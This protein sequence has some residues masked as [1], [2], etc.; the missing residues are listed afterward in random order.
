[1]AHSGVST[2]VVPQP[3]NL[4]MNI[5]VDAEGDLTWLAA[6]SRP[7]DAVTFTAEMDCVVVVSACPMD[8]NSINGDGLT[9]LA[10]DV[11]SPNSLL[12]K[13]V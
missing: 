7:G 13:E 8:L 4:F 5:P 9:P 11:T 1:L 3:V 10:I 12:S 6:V 2:D